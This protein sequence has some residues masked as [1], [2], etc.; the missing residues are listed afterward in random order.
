MLTMN[1]T[2]LNSLHQRLRYRHANSFAKPFLDPQRFVRNQMRQIFRPESGSVQVI[3][4]FHTRDFTIVAGEIVSEDLACYGFMEPELTEAFLHLVKPKHV[5]VDIG[6]HLGYFTSL[7]ATLVGPQG[8]VYSFEP[9]P[10]TRDIAALNTSK[11]D[12]VSVYP[13]A[14][15]S[16]QETMTFHDYGSTYMAFNSVTAAR[17]N[18][19]INKVSEHQVKSIS[20]D[21]FRHHIDRPIDI[22]KIDAESAEEQIL[23]GARELLQRDRPIVT[24]EVGDEAADIGRS[25]SLIQTLGSMGYAPWEFLND[26]FRRHQH[27][28]I[29]VY[30]NLVFAPADRPLA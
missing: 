18:Q 19:A 1:Q 24:L 28:D 15:W 30:D 23:A 13:N 25:Q 27:R 3:D 4:T 26:A 29:Y 5:A 10:S 9:T 8:K 11:F 6:M 21:E 20:L 16:R 17:M 2:L 14:V 7:F 12:N 22:I